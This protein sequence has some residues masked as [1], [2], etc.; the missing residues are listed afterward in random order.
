MTLVLGLPQFLA[1]SMWEL[2]I[3]VAHEM[4]HFRTRHTTIVVFLFRFL[5]SLSR[6][7]EP[8]QRRWWRWADP[9][10]WMFSAFHHLVW[11]LSAPIERRQELRADAV[12]AAL[13]G[14]EL[15]VRTLLKD[16]LLANQ[17]E[18]E[19]S[20]YRRTLAAGSRTPLPNLYRFFEERWREYSPES[21]EYLERRLV[22][23][24]PETADAARPSLGTRIALL[25]S[26]PP[27]PQPEPRLA[28]HLLPRLAELESQLM[29]T[30][31]PN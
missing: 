17:F 9:I 14:G 12:S 1:L 15:A 6:A 31:R 25:R 18:S 4:V 3:I 28:A 26:F 7:V 24:D 10:Y 8:L 27:Q 23:E 21:Q 30:W 16:W 29:T 19:V 22:E 5:E 2:R 11:R 13:Y 20:D